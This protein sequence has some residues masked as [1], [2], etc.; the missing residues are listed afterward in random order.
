MIVSLM[1]SLIDVVD[2]L[3]LFVFF[4]V[5][6]VKEVNDFTCV[7]LISCSVTCKEVLSYEGVV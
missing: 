4:V 7:T 1:L 3:L 2:N 5:F 6:F